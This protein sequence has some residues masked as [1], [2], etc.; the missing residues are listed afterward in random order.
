MPDRRTLILLAL[1]VFAAGGL[2]FGTV[3]LYSFRPLPPLPQP[4][5]HQTAWSAAEWSHI[6]ADQE[7]CFL[8]NNAWNRDAAGVHFAQEIFDEDVSG[9]RAI[10]WRWRSPWQMWPSIVSYPEMICGNKP[11]DQPMGTFP[12]LP[13][14]PGS[15]RL[16]VDYNIRQQ[17]TG[18]YNLAF[19]MWAVS[20][21]PPSPATIRCEVMVWI[22]NSGQKPAGTL[23]GIVNVNGT[24]YHVYVNEHQ[25]DRSGTNKN[26]WTYVAFVARHPV[27]NGPL[28][29]S[30]F[31]DELQQ[32]NILSPSEW[33]TDVELGNEVA[34]GTGITEIQDFALHLN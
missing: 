9:H 18:I 1:L 16:T 6:S 33:L 13:L 14:H 22:A 11:W 34:E 29:L 5:G 31:L 7:R 17:A 21:L 28:D 30:A 32:R 24:P 23:R 27:L 25:H 10:G 12:G 3:W 26:E 4:S 15:K 8:V 19:S 20:D 2:P